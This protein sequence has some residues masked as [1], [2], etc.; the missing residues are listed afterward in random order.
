M[1]FAFR[2]KNPF[3]F[4]RLTLCRFQSGSYKRSP[5]C[6]MFNYDCIH[7][8]FEHFN[9]KYNF[10]GNLES[11]VF[12]FFFIV[13]CDPRYLAIPNVI[14]GS[15]KYTQ[16]HWPVFFF[17]GLP[18]LPPTKKIIKN[19]GNIPTAQ[20]NVSE[21]MRLN[22]SKTRRFHRTVKTDY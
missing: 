13:Y 5:L 7:D 16:M 2:Q 21:L 10:T 15:I 20:G 22:N 8:G 19:R 1:F 4:L 11:F 9:K 12:F 18:P 6:R 14:R 17:T 3:G